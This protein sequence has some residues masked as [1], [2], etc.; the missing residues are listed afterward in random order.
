M[1]V[2]D[3]AV[4][5]SASDLTEAVDCEYAVLRRLD[6][7]L[8]RAAAAEGTADR[9]GAHIAALGDRHEQRIL[10][11][12]RQHSR[13]A[14]P[15]KVQGKVTAASAT[16]AAQA[17]VQAFASDADVVYQPAFFDGE[18]FGYADFVE[19]T[20]RGWVICDA[21]LARS[22][23]PRA[24][25]QLGAYA[26][27]LGALGLPVAPTVSLLLGNGERADFRDADVAPVFREQRTRLRALLRR[28]RT[29]EPIGWGA[30]DVTACGRC[31]ECEFAAESHNDVILVAGVHAS[32]RVK[33]IDG[34]ISTI[35]EL[36]QAHTAPEGIPATTFGGLRAQARM[37]WAGL[38]AGAGSGAP[39]EYE[40]TDDAA[41][42]L[43]RLPA[44]SPGDL[45]FDFEGD[46]LYDEGDPAVVGLEYLWGVMDTAGSYSPRWAHSRIDERAAL[47][48]FVTEVTARRAEFPDMHIY[49]YAPYETSA[50][51]R[52]A[53]RNQVME[54]PLDDLLRS[55]VFVDLYATVRGSI[56]VS[57]RSYSIKTLEPLYMGNEL[58]SDE[59]DAVADG[60]AS[61]VAYHEYREMSIDDPAAAQERLDALA[62]YNQYDCLSTLR[63][64]DWLLDR[65][66]DAGVRHLIRPHT[67]VATG[68]ELST[69][70]ALFLDLMARAEPRGGHVRT[71]E[72][73][74]Y[75]LL[76]TALD[77]HRRESKQFWWGHFD[78]LS[79]PMG[80]WQ[81]T[82]DI[83]IVE[84]ARVEKDWEHPGGRARN[85]FRTVGLTGD[86]T[87]GSKLGKPQV[88]YKALGPVGSTGPELAPFAAAPAAGVEAGGDP[89]EIVL[90]ES[91][92]QSDT[93]DDLPV[94]LMPSPPPSA[95]AIEQA[96][97][98]VA[99][100]IE[101]CAVLPNTAI[102]DLLTSRPP[103]LTDGDPLPHGG[104]EIENVVTA[105]LGMSDSYVAVQGP[106]GT[107]KTYTGSRVIRQLVE[108]SGWR[109]GVVAQSHAVVENMLSAI[110]SAGL[111]PALVGKDKSKG[112]TASP[113][114]TP[115]AEVDQFLDD[116]A[117]SGCVV[118][119][120]AWDFT[121]GKK[122][123][124]GT[125]D[126]LVIDEAGQFALANTIAV[127][128]AAQRLLLL[129]D[130]Q[131]L[132]QV[133]QGTHAEPV[134][135]SAL[136]WLLGDHRAM[137]ADRG[138]FLAETHRM[139]PR[140]C[141][142]VSTL[143]YEDRL[144]AAPTVNRRRLAT[145]EPGLHVVTVDHSGNRTESPEEADVI[146]ARI[147][148]V[149]GLQWSADDDG[150]RSL[151]QRDILVV[152]PYNAQV[153][154]LSAALEK[155]GLSDVRVGTV[156][157]FQGQEAPVVFV[158][159]TAS[160]HGDVPRGMGF[161]LNRNRINV[162]ISRA[163]WACF[164][165]RSATLTAFMPSSA[166]G[167][168]ELGAFI[169][170]CEPTD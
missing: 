64:R 169:G 53:M 70:D 146:V 152:A 138:Y 140:L 10:D 15:A 16:A 76:A 33:F 69:D 75:A 109:I 24:L 51:K 116:A 45:F 91:R 82:R 8:G 49:H 14:I 151:E 144:I 39:V 113:A 37:Q 104:G 58:R 95:G 20:D 149:I 126:L 42:T 4:V 60:G 111:S 59:E 25:L 153:Q 123:R 141:A 63:L 38:R 128:I 22:A 41:N 100:Q 145:I 147:H 31:A 90:I 52:L 3:D 86:W 81:R 103:R 18:F 134:D 101:S 164:L 36:A 112:N 132:P 97:R 55:E 150:A 56:R 108:R 159:M 57:A 46:P 167:V 92:P 161:L 61:V 115:V 88:V 30:D 77:Y 67:E 127:S 154:V 133:S 125:L 78:R 7:L 121:N 68:D 54:K 50:L 142:R 131:Q 29:A 124:P 137:P 162:A 1:I 62:D 122:V 99:Q 80:E 72:Q 87:A 168:L 96:I 155:A 94:A 13:V 139:H 117:D 85:W 19:R 136:G 98:A 32:Q 47:I 170:L 106:P 43:A 23:K 119:G 48:A 83:F 102:V 17:A 118:G 2:V 160:S 71:A 21:K 79:R 110:I 6:Y 166:S 12:Y 35:G 148:T 158:S 74:A 143:S 5:W 84:S 28:H 26:E 9:L 130:P 157:I 105:L 129:G 40:L 135:Q 163:Q 27:Q 156:D 120:T 89:R 73:Q 66:T 65:A 165:I 93:F 107:G 44:P 11:R 34:G 114:W